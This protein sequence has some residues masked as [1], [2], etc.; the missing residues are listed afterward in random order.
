MPE[1]LTD[2]VS[3]AASLKNEASG[4]TVAI[5]LARISEK[6]DKDGRSFF[7]RFNVP[8]VPRGVYIVEMSAEVQGLAAR[9]ARKIR[10]E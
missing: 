7:V 8:A 5:P 1:K 4:G 6:N 2:E 3:L 10:I 9:F